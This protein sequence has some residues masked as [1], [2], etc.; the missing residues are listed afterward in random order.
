MDLAEVFLFF[1]FKPSIVDLQYVSF[2][3]MK[4]IW[5]C[6]CAR[7]FFFSIT[8]HYKILNIVPYAI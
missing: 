6:M 5:I 7:V 4:V 3:C 8:H 1:F 2:K